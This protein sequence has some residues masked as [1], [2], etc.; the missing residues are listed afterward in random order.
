LHHISSSG[1]VIKLKNHLD[2]EC[3]SFERE[4]ELGLR[5]SVRIKRTE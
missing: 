3:Q 1:P 2:A 5:N 4:N